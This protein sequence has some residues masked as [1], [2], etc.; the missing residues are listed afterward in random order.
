MY[1]CICSYVCAPHGFWRL[2]EFDLHDLFPTVV[3]LD[4]HTEDGQFVSF[5]RTSNLKNKL[6][7]LKDTKLT[8]WMRYLRMNPTDELAKSL[9]YAQFPQQYR[10]IE[11]VKTGTNKSAGGWIKRT[12]MSH[13]PD[14]VNAIGRVYYVFPTFKETYCL[15]ILLHTIKV[16]TQED[17]RRIKH[18]YGE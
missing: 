7:H 11:G 18:T 16:R 3:P 9:T 4:V 6:S 15:R 1:Y 17:T 14:I 12:Q 2:F 13:D 8:A 5:T 10:W